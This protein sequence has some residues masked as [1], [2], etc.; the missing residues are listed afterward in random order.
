M[1]GSFVNIDQQDSQQD[2]N[3]YLVEDMGD[4]DFSGQRQN[5]NGRGSISYDPNNNDED[6]Q[7]LDQQQEV[8]VQIINETRETLSENTISN[9]RAQSN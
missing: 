6:D 3:P 2:D 5:E 1:D 8:V 7:M 4:D 9:L